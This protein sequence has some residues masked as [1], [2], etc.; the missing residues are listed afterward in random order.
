ML[1]NIVILYP[2]R[3]NA[4][5]DALLGNGKAIIIHILHKLVIHTPIRLGVRRT[6][7]LFAYDVLLDNIYIL[8]FWL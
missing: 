1:H 2:Q 3:H 8:E 4:H 6:P 7:W 5:R